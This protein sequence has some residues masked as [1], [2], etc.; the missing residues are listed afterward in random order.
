MSN[1]FN[2]VALHNRNWS[3]QVVLGCPDISIDLTILPH[4]ERHLDLCMRVCNVHQ[5]GCAGLIRSM[6]SFSSVFVLSFARSL[7]PV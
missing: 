1:V 2:S 5:Y 4:S 7:V 3:L 6:F